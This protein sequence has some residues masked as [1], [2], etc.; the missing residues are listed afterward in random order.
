M[1]EITVEEAQKLIDSWRR[2]ANERAARIKKGQYTDQSDR[3][4]SYMVLL[5]LRRC[6]NALRRKVNQHG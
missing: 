5:T 2:E 4:R 3:V 1:T 6:A